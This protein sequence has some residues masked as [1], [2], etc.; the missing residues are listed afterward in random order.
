MQSHLKV[1]IR[2]GKV[3]FRS[4]IVHTGHVTEVPKQVLH[5]RWVIANDYRPCSSSSAPRNLTGT[6]QRTGT[7]AK[8]LADVC[9][10]GPLD[11]W[12]PLS[13]ARHPG[14]IVCIRARTNC[15]G[16]LYSSIKDETKQRRSDV[17]YYSPVLK[18]LSSPLSSV[19]T[20]DPTSRAFSRGR[21]GC[22]LSC[23]N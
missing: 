17:R 4:L 16:M 21:Y 19:G 3:K 20:T 2:C 7:F 15:T 8:A 12:W 11:D 18:K 23:V 22:D 1:P 5:I 14:Q 9:T 10:L 6:K 13:Y